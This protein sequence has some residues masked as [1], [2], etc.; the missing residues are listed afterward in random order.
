MQV[1]ILDDLDQAPNFVPLFEYHADI[2]GSLFFRKNLSERNNSAIIQLSTDMSFSEWK[3]ILAQIDDSPQNINMY[4]FSESFIST[5]D[6]VHFR[7]FSPYEMAINFYGPLEPGPY[8]NMRGQS[9][10]SSPNFSDTNWISM[11]GIGNDG[12]NAGVFSLVGSTEDPS[13]STKATHV[14]IGISRPAF[15]IEEKWESSSD[16]GNDEWTLI[17][18]IYGPFSRDSQ[19]IAMI[20]YWKNGPE[21]ANKLELYSIPADFS[22]GPARVE[23]DWPVVPIK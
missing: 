18:T 13:G 16:D 7:Q 12:I 8:W 2:P 21:E 20:K 3:D 11:T 6:T 4:P 15:E 22:S 5:A 1:P 19:D 10:V 23:L 14:G 9:V 17:D